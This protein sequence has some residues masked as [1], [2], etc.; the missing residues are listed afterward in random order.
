MVVTNILNDS[1]VR[2]KNGYQL[3][4]DSILILRSKKVI[5]VLDV[6]YLEGFIRGYS[7][8]TSDKGKINVLLKYSS[9]GRGS[10]KNIKGI[11]RSGKRVYV[12]I[13]TLW[14]MNSRSNLGCYILSTS[15][16]VMSLKHAL[17]FNVGGELLCYVS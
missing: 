11:S 7:L 2:I 1:Y 14:N 5:R 4:L 15:K 12:S 8:D 16:G 6:L 9:E 10:L 3:G 17:K 13:A